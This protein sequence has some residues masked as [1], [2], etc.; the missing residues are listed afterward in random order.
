MCIIFLLN[1]YLLIIKHGNFFES[2]KLH[3]LVMTK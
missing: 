3:R 1:V 2:E